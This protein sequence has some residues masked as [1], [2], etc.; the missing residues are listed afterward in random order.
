MQRISWFSVLVGLALA[1]AAS[2]NPATTQPTGS[3]GRDV[4]VYEGIP[5]GNFV[6]GFGPSFSALLGSGVTGS[7]HDIEGLLKFDLTGFTLAPGE[8][9]KLSLYVLD[10]SVVGFP[11]TNA[12]PSTPASTTIY[13]VGSDW[14]YNTVT[15]AT[16]PPA[17]TQSGTSLVDGINKWVTFDVTNLVDSWL[18]AGQTNNGFLVRQD[19]IVLNG[20]KVTPVYASSRAA[21]NQPILQIVAVPEPTAAGALGLVGAAA[22]LRR[23]KA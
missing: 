15:W 7:G 16:R 5:N 12:S 11:A 10:A 22:L 4:F 1:A 17:G 3:A 19:E 18:N 23:R 21:A 14:T 20:G 2:A 6:A 13:G 9:A 8:T